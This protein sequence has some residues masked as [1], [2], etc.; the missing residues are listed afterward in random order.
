MWI[1]LQASICTEWAH[2]RLVLKQG[3]Q[4]AA[5]LKL[6][7]ENILKKSTFHQELDSLH[8]LQTNSYKQVKLHNP[9]IVVS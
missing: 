5:Q 4:N 7:K 3:Q 2:E 6:S 9:F 1:H 8:E